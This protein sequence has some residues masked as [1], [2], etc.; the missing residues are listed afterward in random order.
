MIKSFFAAAYMMIPIITQA[1]VPDQWN[2]DF[3]ITLSHSGSMSGGST[4]IE[5]TY[6]QCIFNSTPSYDKKAEKRVFK[7]TEARRAEI[8]AKMRSLQV[9]SI[10]SKP[11]NY[12]V[13]DGWS[14]SICFKT[15]CIEGGTSAEMS[16]TDKNRFQEAFNYLQQYAYR[17]KAPK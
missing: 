15:Y 2:P 17:K 5:F 13:N 4:H 7:M 12:P 6:D 16:D 11:H 14:K 9:D 3:T 10:K 8:L 1:Q